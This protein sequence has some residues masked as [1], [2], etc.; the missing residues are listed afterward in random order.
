LQVLTD[1][2]IIGGL[3]A[4]WFVLLV[5]W[6]V[7]RGMQAQEPSLRAVALACGA[8]LFGLLVHSLFDFNLQLPSHALLFVAEAAILWQIGAAVVVPAPV[9][10][11]SLEAEAARELQR[12]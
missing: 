4:L 3:L 5:A 2:G 7:R 12:G 9:R 8:G 6:A 10:V 11:R 1:A